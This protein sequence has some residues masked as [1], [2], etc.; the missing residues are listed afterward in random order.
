MGRATFIKLSA[1]SAAAI[2]L[3]AMELNIL[4]YAY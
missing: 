2:T 3:Q 1:F 4:A